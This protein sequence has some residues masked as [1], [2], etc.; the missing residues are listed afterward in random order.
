M[1]TPQLISF[2]ILFSLL[3]SACEKEQAEDLSNE[4]INIA[5]AEEL[6][7]FSPLTYEAKNRRYLANIYETLLSYDKSFNYEPSLALSWGRIDDLTW[8]FNLRK[9]VLF[10]DQSTF[11]AADFIYSIE[12]A[13]SDDDSGLSSLLSNIESVEQS[14]DY[15]VQIMTYEPDPLLLNKLINVY[16]MPDGF[17]DFESP[18]G[19][20]PYYFM[21]KNKDTI[22]LNRF[23]SYWGEKPYFKEADLIFIPD[24]EDRLSATL[25]G[26]VQFLVN[27][28]P[29]YVGQLKENNYMIT[30]FP[31]LEVSYLMLNFDGV[32]A[33]A[34][35]REAIWNALGEDYAQKFGA[36]YLRSTDQYA[37]SGI[38]GY[39]PDQE[40]RVKNIEKAMEFRTQIE[41]DV[42]LKLAIPEGLESLAEQISS[43]LAEIDITVEVDVIPSTV[44]EERILSGEADMYF[45]GWKFDLAD[46]A[47]F[48]ESV[49]HSKDENYGSFNGM[50]YLNESVDE[51][52]EEAS[53]LLDTKERRDT[54][55][56]INSEL[57]QARVGIPLFEAE[58]IYGISSGISWETRLDGQVLA[59]EIR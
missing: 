39:T 19:T 1:K 48:F 32:L 22:S 53:T 59:G 51:L 24:P 28:P 35:L 43:D 50:N 47:D 2:V 11:D 42:T 14:S 55:L 13:M 58:L 7:E 18:I 30:G 26:R 56:R 9:N 21:Y 3:F 33:D 20:A 8:E 17:S 40:A 4:K 15:K 23:E 29:Q 36:G 49:V 52:I 38:F 54:L 57:L 27:V 5:Y 46:S 16:V 41:G 6:T 31:S 12:A 34:N 25:E 37:A 10:H 44:Y 45:F